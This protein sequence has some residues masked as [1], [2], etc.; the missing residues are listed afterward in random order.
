[1]VI[2]HIYIYI[3]LNFLY[4]Y[5]SILYVV[6]NIIGNVSCCHTIDVGLVFAR[7]GSNQSNYDHRMIG[8]GVIG[9]FLKVVFEMFRTL[10]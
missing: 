7:P 9:H 10:F 3:Y 6:Y 1:M 4:V 5:F 2:D 8:C